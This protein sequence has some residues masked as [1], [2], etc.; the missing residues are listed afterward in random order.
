VKD[1][2]GKD[3]KEIKAPSM[4]KTV[5]AEWLDIVDSKTEEAYIENWDRF[6]VA[7]A[8]FLKILRYVEKTI[9]DLVKEK[10]VRFWVN[11]TMHMGNIT[12]N[13]AESA[14]ARLKKYLSSSMSELSTNSKS[15]HD[16]LES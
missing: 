11:K 14:H 15:V 10:F 1:L 12:T 7:C 5:M 8:K 4:V 13:R 6:K 3:G 16:M 9:L 2:K